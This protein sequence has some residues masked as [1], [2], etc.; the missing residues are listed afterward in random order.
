MK[1]FLELLRDAKCELSQIIEPGCQTLSWSPFSV[2]GYLDPF[3]AELSLIEE[4]LNQV[5]AIRAFPINR[6]FRA[7][8]KTRRIPQ[9]KDRIT[10][11]RELLD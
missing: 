11:A 7:I 6:S 10:D 4:A 5:N 1:I 2:D 9:L 8:P 3:G